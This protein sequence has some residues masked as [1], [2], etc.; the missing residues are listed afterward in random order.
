M[1][2]SISSL[3]LLLGHVGE[4]ADVLVQVACNAR[5]ADHMFLDHILVKHIL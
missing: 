1:V 5:N 4:D 2:R 3:R